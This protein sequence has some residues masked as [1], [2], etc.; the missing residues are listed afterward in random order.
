MLLAKCKLNQQN[1]NYDRKTY[2]QQVEELNKSLEDLT[3]AIEM[4]KTPNSKM[5]LKTIKT[6]INE[7]PP[8][9]R[10]KII[11]QTKQALL[12]LMILVFRYIGFKRLW[13]REKP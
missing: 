7:F 3:P 8:K 13:P 1:R 11:P 12:I 5:T 10:N 2:K 6:F 4:L 9:D